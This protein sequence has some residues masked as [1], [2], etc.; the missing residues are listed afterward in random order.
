MQ[1]KFHIEK[2]AVA[3]FAPSVHLKTVNY[4]K[5]G[6]AWPWSQ[7]QANLVAETFSTK[8]KTWLNGRVKENTC[9]YILNYILFGTGPCL[10][11][12]KPDFMFTVYVVSAVFCYGN[13]WM[14]SKY[15]IIQRLAHQCQWTV[16]RRSESPTCCCI[17]LQMSLCFA[18]NVISLCY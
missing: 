14:S 11:S 16:Y 10:R 7:V 6:N 4:T 1:V 5:F 3:T 8:I 15:W 17:C 9:T 12:C 13:G 2:S 18:V